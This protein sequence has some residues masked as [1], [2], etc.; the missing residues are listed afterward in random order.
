[1]VSEL[2][3]AENLNAATAAWG[4]QMT[5]AY[6]EHLVLAGELTEAEGSDQRLF[7]GT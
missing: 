6:L 2:I 7:A 1:M 5:L 4:L 3:G